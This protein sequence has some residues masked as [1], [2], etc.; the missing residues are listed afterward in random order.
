MLVDLGRGADHQRTLGS[1]HN[2]TLCDAG[3]GELEGIRDTVERIAVVLLLFLP[4]ME[5]AF[6]RLMTYGGD[7]VLAVG[8]E[9]ALESEL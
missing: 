8:V 3:R 7:Y 5:S 2:G 1:G 6:T 4:G 9:V